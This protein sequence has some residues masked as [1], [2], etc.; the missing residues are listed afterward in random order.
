MKGGLSDYD[1][2]YTIIIRDLK[3]NNFGL[4]T[5]DRLSDIK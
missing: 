5:L 2:V 1:K 3:D 4:I